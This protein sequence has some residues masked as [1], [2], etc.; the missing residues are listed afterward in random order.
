M[1][2][3]TDDQKIDLVEPGQIAAE[4]RRV[5]ADDFVRNSYGPFAYYTIRHRA[6]VG[7]DGLKPVN[8]RIL[9]SMLRFGVSPDTSHQKAA[10]IAGYC[11]TWHPH[12]DA[13]I[14]DAMARMGQKFSMR[15]PLIDVKGSVGFT[16]GDKPASPRYWEARPTDAA[17]EL[18]NEIKSGAVELGK[19]YDGSEDEP[20]QL[21]VRFPNNIINGSE[22]IAVGYASKMPSHNPSEVMDAVLLGIKKKEK[23][24]AA[25]ILKVM[26]GPD[27]PTGGELLEIEGIKEYYETGSGR[28]LI[29]GKPEIESLP[30]GRSKI[31]FSELPFAVSAEK[32]MEGIDVAKSKGKLKEIS[33]VKDL[34]DKR[35]GLRLVIETKSGTNPKQVLSEIFKLTAAESPFSVNNTVLVDGLPTVVSMVELILRFI[36]FRKLC[37][38]NKANF[39]KAKIANRILQLDALL[40]V[41]VDIDKC[42]AIIRSSESQDDAKKELVKKFKITEDQ[43]DYVLAM[44]LRRL[45]KADSIALEK[46]RKSL[47]EEQQSL[48]EMLADEDLILKQVAK[49]VKE[50]K[51]VIADERRTTISGMTSEDI[52]EREKALRE[53]AKI[54]DKNLECYITR[55]AN[56]KLLKTLEPYSYKA[57][58]KRI[59]N[60]PIVEQIK[61]MTKDNI[62]VIGSDGIGRRIP[63]SYLVNNSPSDNKNYGVDLPRGVEAVG[64]S[65]ATMTGDEQGVMMM[66]NQGSI[67]TAKTDFPIGGDEFTVFNIDSDER[68]VSSRWVSEPGGYALS[69]SSDSNLLCFS[70]D[71]VRASGAKAG[72]VRGQ[73]LAAGQE[74]VHFTWLPSDAFTATSANDAHKVVT[75]ADHTLKITLLMEYS[76]KGRGTQGMRSHPFKKG[77]SQVVSAFVGNQVIATIAGKST[78]VNLP[79][80]SKKATIGSELKFDIDLGI[81]PTE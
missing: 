18:L 25:D 58:A 49:E 45:T 7:D 34:T 27:F 54:E 6:L 51:K 71:E 41:L 55:F 48:D 74:V 2:K 69:I 79:P 66:T 3:T 43:A 67:K 70:A 14:A 40:S 50:T 36:E 46:E 60:G 47:G 68:I 15:T 22:G 53:A 81:N 76:T 21:P 8:R 77:E 37:V 16:S 35:Y 57:G 13:S 56:G 9:Y 38:I 73:K 59:D 10:K 23:L 20:D 29:R 75:K 33:S 80:I 19:N 4:V 24:T 26:P 30:R 39:R 65:K 52:K 62:V 42:I 61:M 17:M 11:T 12:G 44:Q 5:P 31:I 1:A 72:G 64:L 78:A 32:V 63:L 28:F